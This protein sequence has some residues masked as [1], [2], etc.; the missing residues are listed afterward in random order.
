MNSNEIRKRRQ[1]ASERDCGLVDMNNGTYH[2]TVVIQTNNLGIPGLVTSMDQIYDVSCDY[3]SML[4][5]KIST[6]ANMTVHGPTP[7]VINPKGKIELGNRE[8]FGHF[9]FSQ[10]CNSSCFDANDDEGRSTE[11]DHPS[12]T[13]RHS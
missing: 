6:A 12:Q 3:S 2:T 1:V 11:A 8:S 4:G 7:S 9:L 13:G 5:G 10:T